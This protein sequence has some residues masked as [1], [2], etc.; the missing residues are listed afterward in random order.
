MPAQA[1]TA[2]VLHDRERGWHDNI[3]LRGGAT[4]GQR[5]FQVN[6]SDV[7]SVFAAS[8]LPAVGAPFSAAH[9]GLLATVFTPI[10]VGGRDT[11]A[12]NYGW[13]VVRVDYATPRFQQPEV[14]AI[15]NDSFTEWTERTERLE[16]RADIGGAPVPPTNKAGF[17]DV[18]TVKTYRTSVNNAAWLTMR[19][20]VNS[21]A[22]QIP[23]IFGIAGSAFTATAGQLYAES[24]AIRPLGRDGLVEIAYA[25]A[26]ADDHLLR[27]RREDENGEPVGDIVEATIYTPVAY[28]VVF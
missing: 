20:K 9:P 18:L 1:V 13:P 2:N 11:D 23:P 14:L 8:G 10:P 28:P 12:T 21:N 15:E 22:V 25:F 7:E 16:V 6:T 27:F 3:I 19:G 5:F 17:V 26:Y 24:R 4:V